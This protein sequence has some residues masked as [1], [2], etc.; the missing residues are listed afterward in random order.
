MVPFFTKLPR[1]LIGME[2]CGTAHRWARTLRALGH[3]MRLI[4]AAYANAYV[5]LNK[6]DPAS[7]CPRAAR[8]ADPWA[9]AICEAVSRPAIKS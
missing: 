1:C 9:D 8:S 7:A 3:E 2:A 5:R 4:P 6:T